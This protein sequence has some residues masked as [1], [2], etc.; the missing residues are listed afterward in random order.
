[1]RTDRTPVADPV[2]EISDNNDNS[3]TT[4]A[5]VADSENKV[6]TVT[7]ANEL[8][9]GDR[10]TIKS[11]ADGCVH[12]QPKPAT[13]VQRYTGDEEPKGHKR[14]HEQL[15]EHFAAADSGACRIHRRRR[16]VRRS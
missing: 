10:L 1:M 8:K 3:I 11:G 2:V 4:I 16:Y 6:W 12:R 14:G 7:F 13:F 15:G 9:A 5:P